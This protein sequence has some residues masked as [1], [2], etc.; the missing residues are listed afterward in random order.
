MFQRQTNEGL[1]EE[2]LTWLNVLPQHADVAVSVGATLL[3]VEAEGVEQL[4]LD[5]AV[6]QAALAIQGQGLGITLATHVR[7]TPA[8]RQQSQ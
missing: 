2:V 8:C 4:V 6:V 7:V 1:I 3:V 5:R